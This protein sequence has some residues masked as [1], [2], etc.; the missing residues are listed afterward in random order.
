MI[1]RSAVIIRPRQPYIDWAARLDDSGLLPDP[2]AEPTIYL[3]PDYDD[4]DEAWDLLAK[5][6]T[7]IFEAELWGWHTVESDWP[8]E[9]TFALFREWLDITFCSCLED[10]CTDQIVN[11]EDDL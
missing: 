9:R 6:Y 11:D 4:D 5:Y 2:N 1:N 10:L 7:E 3:I 8:T